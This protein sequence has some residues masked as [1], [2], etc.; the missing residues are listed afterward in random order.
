[1]A[2]NTDQTIDSLDVATIQQ[3]TILMP[4]VI[5]SPRLVIDFPTVVITTSD[6]IHDVKIRGRGDVKR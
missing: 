2:T 4:G 1:M 3:H 6:L 5:G